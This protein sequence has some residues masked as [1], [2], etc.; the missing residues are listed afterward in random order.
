MVSNGTEG[1]K[2]LDEYAWGK[3]LK[4]AFKH[5]KSADVNVG[6]QGLNMKYLALGSAGLEFI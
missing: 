2:S 5:G 4:T 3:L 1:R 6:K